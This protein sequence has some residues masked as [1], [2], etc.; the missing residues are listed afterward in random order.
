VVTTDMNNPQTAT[1]SPATQPAMP[2]AAMPH[3]AMP[4]AAMPHA[5][6][7][8]AAMPMLRAGAALSGASYAVVLVHGRG[9]SPE[10]MVP[11]A[12]A[13]G[14][15]DGAILAP[16]AADGSWYP[17]RFLAPV[18]QNEP[19]LSSA[20]E[21]VDAAVQ[22]AVDAGI[23][24]A[25]IVL[26]G[27]SQGA[28]LSLEYAARHPARYGAVAGLAG[29]LIGEDGSVRVLD[30]ALAGTPVLLACGDRDAHIPEAR[31]RSSG[32]SF[33]LAGATTDVRVYA[34]LGHEIIEDQVEA[35]RTLIEVVRGAT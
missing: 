34:G 31:V 29:A 30:A 28:C 3:A 13:A 14:A 21:A 5:A 16:R 7:P 17:A 11:L 18:R 20:L 2:H 8:H 33:R 15:S 24:R 12:L 27:F 22:V 26:S 6:M 1:P 19:W 9:G 4:H 10:S 23:P 35:L 25:H 32:E